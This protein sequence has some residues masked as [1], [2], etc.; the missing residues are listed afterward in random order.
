MDNYQLLKSMHLLGVTL[1]L[2]NIIV[3]AVWKVLADRTKS[4]EIVAY[5]QRLVTITDFA[6]TAV[7]VL[8]IL[9]SGRMMASK[10]GGVS[11]ILWL[12]W[13]WWLFIASGVIWIS[14][15]IPVQVKQARMARKFSDKDTIPQGYWTLSKYWAAFG[16][17]ATVLPLANLFF[18]VFKPT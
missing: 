11:D 12:T 7:G 2:G 14:V 13:G 15:L 6:F 10:F 5:S 18:M 4:P 8:L 1:F 9:V 17:V 16:T 3:T